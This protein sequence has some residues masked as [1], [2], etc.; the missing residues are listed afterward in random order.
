MHS[1][2]IFAWLCGAAAL[3]LAPAA[4]AQDASVID[5][6]EIVV[7]PN[8]TPTEK[9]KVGSKVEKVGRE[10]IE[11]QSLPQLT[12]YLTLMPGVAF[13]SPGGIGTEG[14]LAVRGAARRYVKT[15]YNGIDISDPTNTQVQTSY[16]YL[17]ADGIN[18]IELLKGS[19]S[20]LYGS[21]AIA[22]VLSVS[23]LGGIELGVRHLIQA[24][25]GSYGTARG[26]YGLRAADDAGSLALNL[27]GF[28][29]D[30]ISAASAG[31]ER[32]GYE[33]VTFD[34]AGEYRINDVLSVFASGLYIDAMAEFDDDFSS[35]PA[36][37]AFGSN[38]NR[39][40]QIAGRMGFNIDLLD[41]RLKNTFSV[42]GFDLNRE[43]NLVSGF[44]PYNAL[45][46]GQRLKA[47]YQGSFEATEWLT[48]QYGADHEEQR[49]EFGDD[50]GS[51]PFSGTASLTG[52]W[53]QA[54]LAPLENVSLSLGARHDEHDVFG[55]ATTWRATGAYLIPETATKLHASAGTGFRAP[56]LYELFAPPL[57]AG[58]VPVGNAGLQPETSTSFDIG[59]EQ[60]FFDGRLVTDITYF[61]IEIEDLIQCVDNGP[62]SCAYQQV[63]GT[64]RQRGVETSAVWQAADWLDL[65]AAY[66]YT[67]SE[68]PDGS[69]NIRVPRHTVGL[70]ASANPWEKWFFSAAARI[71]ADTV[72]TGGFKLDD[73]VLI[74]AKVAYKPTQDTEIYLRADN[75]L[76]VDY[77][78]VRGFGTPGLSVFGG[79]K[80]AF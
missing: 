2:R 5:L 20:T 3:A 75:L 61:Q 6:G 28:R 18:A 62:F 36:D 57:F 35:P 42:Q 45:Y 68:L 63:P 46:E 56:S 44:G 71:A 12:D 15:Q 43:I 49:A 47:D 7:T 53:A 78:T 67:E 54:N 13:S 31:T 55:G 80:A 76:D 22:G 48:L 64:S 79:F 26:S 60:G 16:Q 73:Y 9:A 34:A 77:E 65:G 1:K 17:L 27:T 29:T 74:N 66:T 4:Q 39:N 58:G 51:L 72:D 41:G 10:E 11:A 50:A 24:E 37:D 33:N 52:L 14:S 30:G 23:T 19:Q 8:R 21:D 38:R 70:T 59:I 32:D 25:G 40:R 69:R